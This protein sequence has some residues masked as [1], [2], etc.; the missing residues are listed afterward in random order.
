MAMS[1]DSAYVVHFGEHTDWNAL[2]ESSEWQPLTTDQVDDSEPVQR[3]HFSAFFG[4]THGTT[5]RYALSP[6]HSLGRTLRIVRYCLTVWMD[7]RLWLLLRRGLRARIL[8]RRR[9]RA[10]AASLKQRLETL[11]GWLAYWQEAE[12]KT[13]EELRGRLRSPRATAPMTHGQAE[14]I[15]LAQVMTSTSEKVKWQVIWELYWLL[16]AQYQ[17]QRELYWSRWR[18]LSQRRNMLRASQWAASPKGKLRQDFVQEEPVS[19]RAVNAALFVLALQ[20]PQFRYRAGQEVMYKELLRLANA[21]P[22]LFRSNSTDPWLRHAPGA[23]TAFLDS[24][25][26]TT[27][28]WLRKRFTMPA[29]LIPP[30]TWRS[31]P[32]GLRRSLLVEDLADTPEDLQLLQLLE[33]QAG[34][35]TGRRLGTSPPVGLVHSP[36]FMARRHTSLFPRQSSTTSSEASS[37]AERGR[38]SVVSTLLGSPPLHSRPAM[39]HQR[40][41]PDLLAGLQSSPRTPRPGPI[42]ARASSNGLEGSDPPLGLQPTPFSPPRHHS[43][44]GVAPHKDGGPRRPVTELPP[45]GA[46]PR[47]PTKIFSLPPLR[48]LP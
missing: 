44:R 41:V 35:P 29:A 19:L 43:T 46:S 42:F 3:C 2:H 33:E 28:S 45:G 36:R 31:D 6:R 48:H 4:A 38:P 47:G 5:A 27:Q 21:P 11:E 8:L 20:V 12:L 26:C 17:V 23:L 18:T 30:R 32:R 16:Y 9:M 39:P 13:H 15:A 7:S 14:Q 34:L 10:L 24:P 25:L 37:S 22:P 1:L 40:S